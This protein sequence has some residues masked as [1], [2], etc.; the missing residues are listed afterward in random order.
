MGRLLVD[1]RTVVPLLLLHLESLSCAMYRNSV[2]MG[3]EFGTKVQ[4]II[5]LFPENSV[6]FVTVGCDPSVHSTTHR[7]MYNYCFRFQQNSVASDA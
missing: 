6:P 1:C 4:G 3:A 2:P 5:C 7:I